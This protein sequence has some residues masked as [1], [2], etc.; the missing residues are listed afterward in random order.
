MWNSFLVCP[1]RWQL[2]AAALWCL[3]QCLLLCPGR[4]VPPRPL[5]Y[6]IQCRALLHCPTP[7]PRILAQP[8]AVH[9]FNSCPPVI[10]LSS[11]AQH[12]L[13]TSHWTM[14]MFLWKPSDPVR[15]SEKLAVIA[16]F[17]LFWLFFSFCCQVKCFPWLPMTKMGFACFSTLPLTVQPA[18][19]MCWSWWCPCWTQRP[20][21]FTMC[22]CKL[23][24]PR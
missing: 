11:A 6:S 14:C 19:P 22:N 24:F 15:A 3:Q 1:L 2:E 13:Q 21:L 23:L 17:L 5:S 4:T 12:E 16:V 9:F 7:R 20:Y 18:D 10:R 8:L